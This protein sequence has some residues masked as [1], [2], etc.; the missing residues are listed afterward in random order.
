M[1]NNPPGPQ[2]RARGGGGGSGGGVCVSA[3]A[4][5]RLPQRRGG[6]F[7]DVYTYMLKRR[8]HS[9]AGYRSVQPVQ[10]HRALLRAMHLVNALLLS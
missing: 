8:T 7:K 4:P 9:M 5:T 10:S 1:L 6:S 3:E 2:G